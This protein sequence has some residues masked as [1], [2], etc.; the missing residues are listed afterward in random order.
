MG[1]I[2]VRVSDV[3][4]LLLEVGL[5]FLDQ[6]RKHDGLRQKAGVLLLEHQ[7]LGV[8]TQPRRV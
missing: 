4:L 3:L 5:S 2:H 1:Y 7:Q 8:I 6:H